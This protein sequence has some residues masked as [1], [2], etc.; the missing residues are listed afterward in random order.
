M[1]RILKGMRLDVPACAFFVS[2]GIAL[3]LAQVES[4]LW[5]KPLPVAG[6]IQSPL[7][8]PGLFLSPF[9]D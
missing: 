7:A 1:E 8:D 3:F 2:L 9:E 5:Q 4:V 6:G